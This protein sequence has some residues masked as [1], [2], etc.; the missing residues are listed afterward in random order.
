MTKHMRTMM[1]AVVAVMLSGTAADAQSKGRECSGVAK[2]METGTIIVEA[3][4][5]AQQVVA[6]RPGRCLLILSGWGPDG[7]VK[8][9]HEK[10][11]TSAAD[12]GFAHSQT[13]GLAHLSLQTEAEVWAVHRATHPSPQSVTFIEL[14]D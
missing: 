14:F 3:G 7:G 4:Q 5:Q 12:S 2:R 13:G 8:I 1:T 6:A 10:S 11:I 9:G